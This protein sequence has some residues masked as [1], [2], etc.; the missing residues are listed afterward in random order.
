M[1]ERK[2]ILPFYVFLILLG[3][4]LIP[5]KSWP[6]ES[7]NTVTF[8]NKSGEH[9]I[10]RVIGPSQQ[11][12]EVPNGESRLVHVSQGEYY[13]LVRY[14]R[15]PKYYRY[16]KGDSFSVTQTSTKY[17][18]ITITL[19]KVVEGNYSTHEVTAEEFNNTSFIAQKPE[20]ALNGK[21][22]AGLAGHLR[23]G[24]GSPVKDGFVKIANRIDWFNAPRTDT[25][26]T[27]KVDQFVISIDG[28][29]RDVAL[30][31]DG[32]FRFDQLM[33]REHYLF[34]KVPGA[35]YAHQTFEKDDSPSLYQ[36]FRNGWF[37]KADHIPYARLVGTMLAPE[38]YAVKQS[39][40]TTP[41]DFILVKELDIQEPKAIEGQ[42]GFY[43]F[44][45]S[46][47]GSSG[48]YEILIFTVEKS[49]RPHPEYTWHQTTEP[50]YQ[51][52]HALQSGRHG[53][54]VKKITAA[55]IVYAQSRIIFFTVP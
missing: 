5:V 36:A 35:Y 28:E 15:K 48:N 17:S 11:A 6:Q 8:D 26:F 41:H 40:V 20:K 16:S 21:R 47:P 51:N 39:S 46:N 54:W 45:W 30:S 44:S 4:A 7:Q 34:F 1:K 42:P 9:A 19:H 24:D 22:S 50:M 43:N 33:E 10:V 52:T 13:I 27:T 31:P 2:S 49:D 25:I 32:R 12:V 29:A 38:I 23:W 55:L 18:A 3:I 53:V 37:Y 14:G